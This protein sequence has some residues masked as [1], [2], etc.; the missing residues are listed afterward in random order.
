[1]I[2]FFFFASINYATKVRGFWEMAKQ[3][4]NLLVNNLKAILIRKCQKKYYLYIPIRGFSGK[5]AL[6]K[7]NSSVALVIVGFVFLLISINRLVADEQ[8]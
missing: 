1:M 6:R 8:S 3:V 5:L 2:F 7:T 4:H